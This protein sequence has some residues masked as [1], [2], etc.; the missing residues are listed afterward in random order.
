MAEQESKPKMYFI[1]LTKR[2]AGKFIAESMNRV[3]A[4]NGRDIIQ[5]KYRQQGSVKDKVEYYLNEEE[6]LND[7]KQL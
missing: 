7:V 1:N 2:T 3:S 4:G 6:W 5:L